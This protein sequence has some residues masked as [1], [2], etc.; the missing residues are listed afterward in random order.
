MKITQAIFETCAAFASQFPDE[1]LPEIALVGKSNVGKSSLINAITRKKGLA[2]TSSTPGKT[3]TAN[4][5]RVNE[6][7]YLVDLPGYGYAKVSRAE[8]DAWRKT[9][10]RYFA[11]RR[12]VC[13]IISVIDCRREADESCKELYEWFSMLELPVVT[14]LTKCDKLSGNEKASAAAAYERKLGLKNKPVLFSSMDTL[15]HAKLLGEIGALLESAK[16]DFS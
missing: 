6:A 10:D 9:I 3:K 15:G 11:G 5:Y 14:V 4:F 7:F 16:T 8:R 13:G 1:T 2:H 12:A